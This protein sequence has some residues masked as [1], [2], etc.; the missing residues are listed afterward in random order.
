ML[1]VTQGCTVL[2]GIRGRATWSSPDRRTEESSCEPVT[3]V[4]GAEGEVSADTE[5]GFLPTVARHSVPPHESTRSRYS[6]C[7]AHV[8]QHPLSHPPSTCLLPSSLRSH[9]Q[10]STKCP[11]PPATGGGGR[12][13]PLPR[14]Q[15]QGLWFLSRDR[16]GTKLHSSTVGT[17]LIPSFFFFWPP[18][19]LCLTPRRYF[20][21]SPPETCCLPSNSCLRICLWENPILD[22]RKRGEAHSLER[23]AVLLSSCCRNKIPRAGRRKQQILIFLMVLEAGSPRRGFS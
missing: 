13:P 17:C 20:L 4:I 16:H 23:E 8:P 7:P 3:W 11:Q 6:G 19:P 15:R 5:W 9:A 12:V 22:T 14:P 21:Q 18:S 2:S 10:G 1:S